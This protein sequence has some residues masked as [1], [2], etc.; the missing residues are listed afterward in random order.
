MAVIPAV[1]G[2]EMA[3]GMPL[4]VNEELLQLNLFRS[5]APESVGAILSTCTIRNASAQEV[6]I[7]PGETRHRFFILLDG[8]VRVHLDS[9]E[10]D[11]ITFIEK[12]EPIGEMAVIDNTVASAYAVADMD[13]RLLELGEDALWSLVE[14][15]HVAACNLLKIFSQRL[16]HANNVIAEKMQLEHSYYHHGSIDTLTGL[17]N[18]YWLDTVLPRQVRRCTIGGKP[19][20][21]IKIDID[22]F[23][24]FNERYGILCGDRAI[25]SIARV[26]VEH[27]R[28]T[29]M[30]ARFDGDKFLVVLP[31]VDI[32]QARHAAER[33]RQK[34]MYA[35]IVMPDGRRLPSLSISLGLAQARPGQTV[36]GLLAVAD[37]AVNRAKQMG[38]NFVSD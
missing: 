36:E 24:Q 1:R 4:P 12:G 23:R 21:V 19:F 16:R 9:I 33:L 28:P 3:S 18:R 20:S 22:W 14:V 38:R 29:E 26:L 13:S 15:S 30:A 6:I 11:P 32:K 8:R 10:S 27:L 31:D 7:T 2:N 5:V 37:S 25:H 17:H 35:D 34:V